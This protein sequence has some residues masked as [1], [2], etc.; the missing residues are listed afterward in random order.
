MWLNLVLCLVSMEKSLSLKSEHVRDEKGHVWVSLL[1]QLIN[2]LASWKS[3]DFVT[4]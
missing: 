4:Y 3:Q 2:L 1:K